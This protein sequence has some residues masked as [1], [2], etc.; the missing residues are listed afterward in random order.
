MAGRGYVL[1]PLATHVSQK[2]Q[3]YGNHNSF[4]AVGLTL[5]FRMGFLSMILAVGQVERTGPFG[6]T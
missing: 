4:S 2:L 5:R 3:F 6:M 1:E